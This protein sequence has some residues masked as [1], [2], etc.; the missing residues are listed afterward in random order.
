MLS[1]LPRILLKAPI[2]AYRYSLSP[3]V[4]QQCRHLPTCSAY[5]LEAID[6]NGAWK[7]FWLG[8]SRVSRCRPWGTSGY[9]PPPDLRQE[10]HP[11]APWRYGRWQ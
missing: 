11:F 10:H 8:I 1:R 7:G 9:D 6:L 5:S 3:L 4:G 2:F